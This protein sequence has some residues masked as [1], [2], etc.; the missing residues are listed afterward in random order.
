ME[1]YS[2]DRYRG[3]H[4]YVQRVALDEDEHEVMYEGIA[5]QNG[6][7]VFTSKSVSSGE[8]AEKKLIRLID[9]DE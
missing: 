2:Y 4:L 5:Q 9:E 3:Y 1:L 6:T 7:T 8:N